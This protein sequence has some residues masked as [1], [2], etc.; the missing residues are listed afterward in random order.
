VSKSGVV[1]GVIGGSSGGYI[2][3]TASGDALSYSWQG[4][5]AS[6]T[7]TGTVG[8]SG[9]LSGTSKDPLCSRVWLCQSCPV[10][11]GTCLNGL[12][13]GGCACDYGPS[14]PNLPPSVPCN[15]STCCFTGGPNAQPNIPN[16]ECADPNGLAC[17]DFINLWFKGATQAAKCPPDGAGSSCT[18]SWQAAP[19]PCPKSA[20]GA[21]LSYDFAN[22]AGTCAAGNAAACTPPPGGCSCPRAGGCNTCGTISA[23]CVP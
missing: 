12:A 18:P 16:C 8:T 17:A 22:Y 14:A 2:A 20:G 5:G 4:N 19:A 21:C 1:T 15:T 23:C 7:G 6:G 3:G 11:G 10:G 9:Q 13:P